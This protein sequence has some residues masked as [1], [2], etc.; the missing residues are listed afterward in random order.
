MPNPRCQRA[1]TSAVGRVSESVYYCFDHLFF[2]WLHAGVRRAC[3]R[4]AVFVQH[5]SELIRN[6]RNTSDPIMQ[7]TPRMATVSPAWGADDL[8]VVIFDCP[9]ISLLGGFCGSPK[10]LHEQNGATAADGAPPA[11]QVGNTARQLRVGYAESVVLR[12][13]SV[14]DGYD[15]A[16]SAEKAV[17]NAK[18]R[19]VGPGSLTA[20]HVH[21]ELGNCRVALRDFEPGAERRTARISQAKVFSLQRQHE[22]SGDAAGKLTCPDLPFSL[23]PTSPDNPKIDHC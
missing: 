7:S 12:F 10:A 20:A 1:F 6:G 5:K 8:P 19:L 18:Q 3:C 2:L 16:T 17:A 4:F 23:S 13:S 11:D 9:D 14:P 22:H 21:Q 15:S